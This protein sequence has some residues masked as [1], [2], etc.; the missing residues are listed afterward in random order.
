MAKKKWPLLTK[1]DDSMEKGVSLSGHEL[2]QWLEGT[3][4]QLHV[5][6]TQTPSASVGAVIK[7]W[8]KLIKF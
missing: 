5:V 6:C 2:H 8:P 7:T 3:F 4:L 1:T